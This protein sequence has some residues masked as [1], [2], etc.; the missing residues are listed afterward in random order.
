MCTYVYVCVHVRM[1]AHGVCMCMCVCGCMFML[2]HVCRSQ[3]TTL[4]KQ[5]SFSTVSVLGIKLR[6]WWQVPLC[7]KLPCGPR[8]VNSGLDAWTVSSLSTELSAQCLEGHLFVLGE[9]SAMHLSLHSPP[10]LWAPMQLQSMG[11]V[12]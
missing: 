10:M 6:F 3:R 7:G 5:F 9:C 11:P 2:Q 12:G 8:D 4:R 1:Y